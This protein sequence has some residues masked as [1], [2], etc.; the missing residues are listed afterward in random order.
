LGMEA[1]MYLTSTKTEPDPDVRMTLA[2]YDPDAGLLGSMRAR[3]LVFGNFNTP[4]LANVRRGGSDGDG[5]M[6]STRSLS[7]PGNDGSQK[8]R[9][10]LPPGWDVTLY[11]NDALVGFQQSR[12]DGLY[13]FEDQP[14]VYGTNEFVLVFNGPLGQTRVERQV[15]ILDQT[16]TKPGEF[17]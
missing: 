12:P 15:F 13:L 8:L 14:L 7:Q 2:R 6:V 9:G 5:V 4:T 10:E 17:F 11:F 3:S 16:L 1:S